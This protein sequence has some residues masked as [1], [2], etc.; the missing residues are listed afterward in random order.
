[1]PTIREAAIAATAKE[2]GI[3]YVPATL[4]SMDDLEAW[5]DNVE[6]NSV[7]ARDATN[8]RRII[9]A[10]I[11]LDQAIVAARAAGDSWD[12]IGAA[13]GISAH[14][15]RQRHGHLTD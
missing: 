15:A 2:R 9:A 12:M 5:L 10:R 4:S 13:L 1:M 14:T 3:A 7:D 8:M 6:V 11:A